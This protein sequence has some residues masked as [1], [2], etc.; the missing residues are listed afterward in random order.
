MLN[1]WQFLK[2]SLQFFF[3]FDTIK[4]EIREKSDF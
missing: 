4:K 2:Y 3:V 1:Y